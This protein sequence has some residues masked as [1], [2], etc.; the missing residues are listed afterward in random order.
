MP[1]D[2]PWCCERVADPPPAVAITFGANTIMF[3]QV[4]P[5]ARCRSAFTLVELLVVIAIIGVLIGLLLPA[6]QAAR[7]SARRTSCINNLHQLGIAFQNHHDVKGGLPASRTLREVEPDL[8]VGNG[9]TIDLLPYIEG[10]NLHERFDFGREYYHETNQEVVL[11]GAD[12]FQCPSTPTFGRIVRLAAFNDPE[13]IE[14][15]VFGAAGDYYVHHTNVVKPDR[16]AAL[17]ALAAFDELTPFQLITDGLSR[18][19]VVNEMAGRPDRYIRGQL[20]ADQFALQKGW[21]AWAGYQSMPLRSY[22]AAGKS[23]G[24]ECVVNCNN[25]SG[26]YSFHPGGSNALFLDASVHFL[27]EEDEIGVVLSLAT[28]DGEEAV[29]SQ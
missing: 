1:V 27:S 22:N 16:T 13:W 15:P 7:E 9:W 12:L 19:I 11:Q 4:P 17:P 28:R 20:M 8:W 18:T 26:I 21:S 24:W 23:P 5:A 29:L 25:D 10:S 6:M 3:A 2:A 14:P